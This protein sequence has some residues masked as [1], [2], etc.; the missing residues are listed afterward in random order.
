[1]TGKT[2]FR[3]ILFL[4]LAL[5]L[6][7]CG[8]HLRGTNTAVATIPISISPVYIK[9]LEQGHYLRTELEN[10]LI[11]SDIQLAKE[12]QEAAATLRI[13]SL[14]SNRRVLAVDSRGKIVEYQLTES[15]TFDLIDQGGAEQ[16]QAQSV[17]MTQS[18]IN[19]EVQ[20]LGA[21]QEEQSLRHDMWRR[22]V[23]QIIRR[24][25]AQLR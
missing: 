2:F 4:G 8:F 14:N 25:A 3:S 21:L 23:D 6:Q 12:P 20:V 18:Y 16:L 15:L 24:L 19:P 11:S 10:R 1:M 22:M 13:S 17:N 9:G 5:T 7:A